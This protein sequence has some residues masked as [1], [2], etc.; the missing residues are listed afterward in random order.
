MEAVVDADGTDAGGN[1]ILGDIG[2]WFVKRLKAE[3]SCDVKY[4]DPTYTYANF[5]VEEQALVIKAERSN[6]ELNALSE[7]TMKYTFF[8]QLQY[9][10]H[11]GLLRACTV[12]RLSRLEVLCHPVQARAPPEQSARRLEQRA[13]AVRPRR[14]SRRPRASARARR[15]RAPR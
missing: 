15:P 7:F 10:V 5:T 12:M 8:Q 6:N 1:P 13:G 9:S 2:P 11:F 14:S 4:I 3:M